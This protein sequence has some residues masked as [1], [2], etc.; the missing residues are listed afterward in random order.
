[1]APV[2]GVFGRAVSLALAGDGVDQDR[3]GGAVAH[4]AQQ[5]QKLV[6]VVPIDRADIGESQ[7]LEQCAAYGHAL[8]HFLGAPRSFLERRRQ[9]AHGALGGGAQILERAAGI[10]AGQIGRERADW[11]GDR[12]LVV[13]QDHDQPLAQMARVVQRL[14]G[15]A[16]A[17]GAVADHGNRIAPIAAQIARHRKAQSRTDR[18]A[19]MAR[20]EGVIGAF[21]PF[22]EPRQPA[23]HAQGTDAVAPPGQDLVGIAL[24]AHVPD[25]LVARRIEHRMQRHGQFHHAQARAQMPAGDA[26]RADRLGAQFVGKLAQFAI[27]QR[28]EVRGQRDPVKD[29]R[30]GKIGHRLALRARI[31]GA[32]NGR[33]VTQVSRSITKR[34]SWRKFPAASP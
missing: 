32:G 27:A 30:G 24:V 20:A 17:H 8:Q 2:G 10:Q 7:L 26:D 13:V 18:G 12:H 9:Q 25:D 21:G 1:M 3:A 11:R 28:L 31:A 22:R 6:Q 34:A 29:W 14:E 4:R 15:H 33:D 16:R 19:G 5:R 23:A